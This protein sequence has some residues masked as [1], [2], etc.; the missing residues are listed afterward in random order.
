MQKKSLTKA[1]TTAPKKTGK[2]KSN[3]S[4][5]SKNVSTM[6]VGLGMRKS[7]GGA[8]SGTM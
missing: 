6:S 2:L 3:A 5:A 1:K 7:S 4:K 8:T